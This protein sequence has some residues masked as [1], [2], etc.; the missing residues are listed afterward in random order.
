MPLR[1]KAGIAC[2]LDASTLRALPA[3]RHSDDRPE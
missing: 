2:K 3:N 1:V